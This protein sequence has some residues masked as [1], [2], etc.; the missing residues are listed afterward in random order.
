M[1]NKSIFEYRCSRCGYIN[2]LTQDIAINMYKEQI[3]C[4]QHCNQRLQIIA[5][6][7]LNHNINLIVSTPEEELI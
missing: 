6:H 1:L 4:C 3:E 5:A 2:T 7:G